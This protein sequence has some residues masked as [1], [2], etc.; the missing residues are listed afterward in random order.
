MKTD[1]FLMI[2]EQFRILCHPY[3]L[4]AAPDVLSGVKLHKKH[5]SAVD[6]AISHI[7]GICTRDYNTH[8]SKSQLPESLFLRP[9]LHRIKGNS[10]IN[11]GDQIRIPGTF[12]AENDLIGS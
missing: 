11:K 9:G 7:P 10:I 8:S 5:I 4:F 3:T 2:P 1:S 12:S 6:P